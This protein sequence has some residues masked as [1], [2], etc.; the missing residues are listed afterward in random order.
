[1]FENGHAWIEGY[2]SNALPAGVSPHSGSRCIGM[3][4]YT[5]INGPH[6]AEFNIKGLDSL[7]GKELYVSAYVYV[8]TTYSLNLDN[9]WASWGDAYMTWS[10]DTPYTAFL[11]ERPYGSPSHPASQRYYRMYMGY[12]DTGGGMNP[13]GT[14]EPYTLPLG[15]WYH[16]EYYVYRD[17]GTNGIVKYWVDGV[18]QFNVSGFQTDSSTND[19]FTTPIK[20]YYGP[21]DTAAHNFI[22]IDDLQIYGSS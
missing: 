2:E 8:P 22:W 3:E 12:R 11:I 1:V 6:R 18:L 17:T 16:L 21:S 14:I 4:V 9:S 5:G 20:I 13:L 7:V 10:V 19:C 15:R